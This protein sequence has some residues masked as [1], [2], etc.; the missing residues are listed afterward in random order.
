MWTE[1][2]GAVSSTVRLEYTPELRA[3]LTQ[4]ASDWGPQ[5]AFLTSPPRSVKSLNGHSEVIEMMEQALAL[6]ASGVFEG[7]GNPGQQ[8]YLYREKSH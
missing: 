7:A 5:I 8:L 6:P 4:L 3:S 1:T 2:N